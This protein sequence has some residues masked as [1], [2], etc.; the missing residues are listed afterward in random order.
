MRQSELWVNRSMI[1]LHMWDYRNNKGRLNTYNQAVSLP[2][3][4]ECFYFE[5]N[6][7]FGDIL[8]FLDLTGNLEPI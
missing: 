4:Y 7:R 5:S 8:K 2:F 1:S 6:K 3:M